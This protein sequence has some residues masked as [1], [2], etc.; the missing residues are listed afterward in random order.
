MAMTLNARAYAFAQALVEAGRFVP[1]HS[2]GWRAHRPSREDEDAFVE[3]HGYDAYGDW[4]L[5][6]DDVHGEQ[7]KGRY[8]FPYGD[9]QMAHRCGLIAAERRADQFGKLDVA[10]AAT[11]LIAMIDARA[12]VR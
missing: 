5:G 10:S 8:R 11:H 9:F 4:H 7:T 2:G 3:A 12:G 6:I 1:D